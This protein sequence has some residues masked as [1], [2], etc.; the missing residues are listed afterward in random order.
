MF[1]S[2]FGG[3]ITAALYLSEFITPWKSRNDS[4]AVEGKGDRS[5]NDTEKAADAKGKELIWFHIDFMGSK[6]GH[7][8]PQGMSAVFEYIKQFLLGP[9]Q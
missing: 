6:N 2:R 1:R 9:I 4:V 7:A 3:A 5:R 8:E